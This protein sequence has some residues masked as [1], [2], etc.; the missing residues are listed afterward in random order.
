MSIPTWCCF[1]SIDFTVDVILFC[2]VAVSVEVK[3]SMVSMVDVWSR[4]SFVISFVIVLFMPVQSAL[5]YSR[6]V[7]G[8]LLYV[9]GWEEKV[10]FIVR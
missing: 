8:C 4:C 9:S 1:I 10:A 2:M 5:W 3:L 7:F 6:I